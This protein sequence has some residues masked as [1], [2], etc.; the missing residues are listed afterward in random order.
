MPSA[1]TALISGGVLIILILA[2]VAVLLWSPLC[3]IRTIT[4]EGAEHSTQEE[5]V[6][7]SGI[8]EGDN[9]LRLDSTGAAQGVAA[10]P[11]TR[12]VTVSRDF[13]STA[14]IRITERQ[15]P[16]YREE[17]GVASLIDENGDIFLQ[18]D[19]P[20][21]AL[22]VT[23]SGSQDGETL[24]EVARALSEVGSE[25]RSALERVDVSAEKAMTLYIKDGR[26]VYWGA[27]ENNRNKAIALE[28]VLTFPDGN[29]NISN[30]ELITRRD[31]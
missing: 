26:T 30:P 23:G 25:Q 21:D 14:T 22:A 7:A 11:W 12:S 28:S 5:I 9:L 2:L 10:L 20:P 24:A 8:H 13:P 19:P 1:R 29:W 3:A 27:T 31:S 15:A 4:V 16:L 6:A 18:G 17:N